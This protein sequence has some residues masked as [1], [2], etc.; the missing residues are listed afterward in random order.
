MANASPKPNVP[1]SRRAEKDFILMPKPSRRVELIAVLN[2]LLLLILMRW[3]TLANLGSQFL[4][5]T[6]GDAG[7]YIWLT[8]SNLRDLLSLPWFNT[9]GFYPYTRSLAWSDNYILPAYAIGVLQF[10]GC[11]LVVATNLILLV[12]NFLNG[13]LTHRLCYQLTGRLMPSLFGGCAFMSFAYL[14]GHVG[15]PQLQYAFWLPLNI[16][17]LLGFLSSPQLR[18]SILLGLCITGTFLSTVYYAVFA[19]LI[20]TCFVISI[21]IMRPHQLKIREWLLLC[22][23]IILGCSPLIVVLRPYLDVLSAFGERQMYE[24]FYFAATPLS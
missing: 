2:L 5:G 12:A 15:H 6:E 21:T 18:N 24:A 13:Y 7:L 11:S 16:S 23:G 14:T 19:A 3:Q 4:G 20:V 8:R 1:G 10:L 9:T 22:S 17:L